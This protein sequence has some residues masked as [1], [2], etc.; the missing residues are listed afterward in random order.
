[1]IKLSRN[2]GHQK[3]IMAGLSHVDL[4]STEIV[5][6]M[7]ADFQDEPADI[8][9]LLD[10]LRQGYDCVYAVRL[11]DSGS[12]IVNILTRVFY[13]TQEKVVSFGIPRHAG[14]FCAFSR[15]VCREILSFTEVEP[16]FPGLRA[17]VGHKQVGVPVARAPRRY[18]QSRVGFW[19][20]LNLSLNGLMGFSP[21]LM[22]AVLYFG[23][24]V[25]AICFMFGVLI[26][27][28]RLLGVSTYSAL[29]RSQYSS[30]G[31]SAYR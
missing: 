25:T 8:P 12:F 24:A 28:L 21:A 13:M 19:G 23:L 26:V 14:A 5:I 3:A 22:R 20:L 29:R 18:G 9:R 31:F 2:F 15:K 7:D 10:K 4:N 11:P 30:W 27:A 16:Y 17:Y 1:M 6:V